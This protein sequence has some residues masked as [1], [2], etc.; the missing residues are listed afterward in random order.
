MVGR[1]IHYHDGFSG[2]T[3]DFM[4][5]RVIYDESRDGY[6][7]RGKRPQDFLFLTFPQIKELLTQGE[8][9][10]TYTI[11]YCGCKDTYKIQKG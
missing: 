11:E 9:Y 4:I 10:K 7:I 5:D 1:M 6:E 3:E 8:Y 2:A